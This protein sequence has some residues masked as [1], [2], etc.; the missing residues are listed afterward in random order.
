MATLYRSVELIANV[1]IILVAV[2]LGAILVN[3]YLLAASNQSVPAQ[4]ER[5]Q[6]QP[7]TKLTLP[8]VEWSNSRRSLLMVL[9][10]TCRYCTESAPFYQR[11]A[12]EKAQHPDFNFVAVLPQSQAESQ[13]YLSDH[14]ITVTEVKHATLASLGVTG[15]PTLILVDDSGSVLNSWIG[16]LPAGVETEVINTF[17]Q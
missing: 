12:A 13:K 9:S 10:T 5:R 15:T 8:G 2:L 1:A 6:I 14:G 17:R 3:K 16:K 4:T 7:G 11:L